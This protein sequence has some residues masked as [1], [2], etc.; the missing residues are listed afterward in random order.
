MQGSHGQL[1]SEALARQRHTSACHQDVNI[2]SD[3]II[4]K[5]LT[6]Q[7]S[8]PEPPCD[9]LTTGQAVFSLQKAP[10]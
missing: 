3:D 4:I 9:C 8:L 5:V 10:D 1:V 2:R 6:M 7:A